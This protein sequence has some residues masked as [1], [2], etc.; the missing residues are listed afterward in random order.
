MGSKKKRDQNKYTLFNN[1]RRIHIHTYIYVCIYIYIYFKTYTCK[2][3]FWKEKP[4][5]AYHFNYTSITRG[6]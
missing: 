4:I 2:I 6:L 3:S 1:Y 5:K